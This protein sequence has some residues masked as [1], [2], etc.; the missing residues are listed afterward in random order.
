MH[1][2]GGIP[3]KKCVMKCSNTLTDFLFG[4]KAWRMSEFGVSCTQH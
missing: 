1:T 3:L 2:E 4:L